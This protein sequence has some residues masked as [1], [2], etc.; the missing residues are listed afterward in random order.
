MLRALELAPANAIALN[1][2]GLLART[3]GR[4]D[5]AIDFFRRALEQDPLSSVYFRNLAGAL[6]DADRFG[7]AEAAYRSA[8]ELAPQ[9]ASMARGN[10]SLTLLAQGRDEDALAEGTRGSD[11]GARSWAQAIVYHRLGHAAESDAALKALIDE[12]SEDM[13]YQIAQVF[14][15]RGEVDRAF[16]WLDRAYAQRDTGLT[17][18]KSSRH[19]RSLHGDPRWGA[20][21]TKMGLVE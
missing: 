19:L 11:G 14:A 12:Y 21:L 16:E 20:F 15:V 13:A 18:M 5:N 2:A 3:F 6:E 4:L 10:L 1:A 7:E 8:L 17:W 9:S